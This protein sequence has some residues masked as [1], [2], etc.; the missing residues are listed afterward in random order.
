MIKVFC[1]QCQ[2]FIKDITP[3]EAG[4]LT[5]EEICEPCRD[6]NRQMFDEIEK[7]K[8]EAIDRLKKT[9]SD[10]QVKLDATIRKC[11]K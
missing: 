6:R 1:V 9:A 7:L 8:R 5:G 4:K 11:L 2:S 3:H 10:M